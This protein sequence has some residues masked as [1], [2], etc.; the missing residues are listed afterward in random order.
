MVNRNI[1][2]GLILKA[3]AAEI[4]FACTCCTDHPGAGDFGLYSLQRPIK[5]VTKTNFKRKLALS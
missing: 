5:T 4:L 1:C 2:A 3:Q